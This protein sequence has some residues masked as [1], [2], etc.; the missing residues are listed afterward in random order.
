[1]SIQQ[2]KSTSV[3]FIDETGGLKL[4]V[5]TT[6]QRPTGTSGIIRQNSTTGLPEWYDSVEDNW[7]AFSRT[8]TYAVQY[9]VIAGG[10]SAGLGAGGGGGAG[11]YRCSVP[12][13]SSGG[14][15]S[16]E[17]PLT[18]T[19]GNAYSMVV[20]AGGAPVV[21]ANTG[22]V[23]GTSSI[24][25]GDTTLVSSV[26]GGGGGYSFDA[27]NR[28]SGGSGGGGG[29]SNSNPPYP[30]SA[31][32]AGTLNQG[33]GGGARNGAR[34]GGG[35][36]AGAVG[37]SANASVTGAGG[38]G[39]SSSINGTATFRAAGGNGYN[40]A[41]V[42]SGGGANFNTAAVINTG[43]GGASENPAGASGII[44]IRYLGAQKGTGGTVTS[45]NG[46][47]IHTF[48]SSGTFTA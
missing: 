26:G 47:T 29:G 17:T 6:E 44:I 21:S 1:M 14:G 45:A 20:G 5:G 39:V 7:F 2:I 42:V 46:F 16:A 27:P 35:G 34:S 36:G 33:R 12:G 8:L 23:G 32:G 43:S 15:G 3:D 11:G 19:R 9:L 13:E 38:V 18:F 24:S 48:T 10:G 41:T 22:N 4:P 31:P 28:R 25:E 37:G 30:G 40:N